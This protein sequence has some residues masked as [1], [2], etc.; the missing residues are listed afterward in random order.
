M[1]TLIIKK[2]ATGDVV[3]TTT[4]LHRLDGAVTWVTAPVNHEL[5]DRL[6]QVRALRWEERERAL[7]RAYDLIV[8]LEDTEEEADFVKEAASAA[9]GTRVFGA[10]RD[11]VGQLVYSDDA[12][13]WFDL[14]LIS[15]Y[16]RERADQLKLE[17]RRTYQELVFSGLGWEFQGEG[18][19]LPP[20]TPTGLTGDVAISPVAGKVWPMKAWAH[21]E[22]LQEELE[23]RGFKV[24]V[25]PKRPTLREHLA[26]VQG[27]R[28]LVSGDSLPMH[29]ALGS[30]V[31]C[32][33][34]FNCTS[35][36]E[37]HDYGLMTK[38]VSPLLEE[39]FYKRIDDPRARTAIPFE[40]VL[41]ATLGALGAS[42]GG[43]G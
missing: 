26:D 42:R 43:R 11:P 18:Y 7:D 15:R 6:P 4:L 24:N 16:G 9:S 19:V 3:R 36:W 2:G 22:R 40:D 35:P 25:L 34:L 17:N 12:S 20:A 5:L 28:V 27:H 21:Y 41:G 23:G 1:S 30:R 14:S 33:T 39:H 10:Q 38:L 29:L 13:A 8:N 37:I 31:R 32:V